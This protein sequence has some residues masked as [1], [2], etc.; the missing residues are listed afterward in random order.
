MD[1]VW[2]Q[3]ELRNA[4]AELKR[5]FREGRV[6]R[7]SANARK[8][9]EVEVAG[10]FIAT[11]IPIGMTIALLFGVWLFLADDQ[12][13]KA[14]LFHDAS[15]EISPLSPIEYYRTLFPWANTGTILSLLIL[16]GPLLA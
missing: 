16:L 1:F 14:M 5:C 10:E 15:K 4:I 9:F 11:L 7:L 8:D 3:L 6:L 13:L 12:P 2:L